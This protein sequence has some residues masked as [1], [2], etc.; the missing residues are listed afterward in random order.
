MN[1]ILIYYYVLKLNSAVINFGC[2]QFLLKT[3]L[4]S[5]TS[6]IL[7]YNNK[8]RLF[9]NY[10]HYQNKQYCHLSG[11]IYN[12]KCNILTKNIFLKMFIF[13]P[14]VKSNL[15]KKLSLFKLFKI[16]LEK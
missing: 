13:S 16:N 8:Y 1:I 15:I 3:S 12:Y 9:F 10:F 11:T 7:K 5:S 4:C 14:R 2:T 6:H